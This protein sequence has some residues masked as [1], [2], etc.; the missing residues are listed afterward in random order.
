MHPTTH[1]LATS[2]KQGCKLNIGIKE[3]FN[4]EHKPMLYIKDF[5]R[6][7]IHDIAKEKKISAQKVIGSKQ[8][9]TAIISRAIQNYNHYLKEHLA[10]IVHFDTKSKLILFVQQFISNK[11]FFTLNGCPFDNLQQLYSKH[12]DSLI[13]LLTIN[14]WNLVRNWLTK[15]LYTLIPNKN[16]KKVSEYILNT[17]QQ[18]CSQAKQKQEPLLIKQELKQLK[19]YINAL[20]EYSKHTN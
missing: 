13:Q 8:R 4:L 19:C 10:K 15:E 6:L 14:N 2:D 9:Q 18:S 16:Y 3:D 5:I 20:S 11:E 12:E 17:I 7:T 1:K